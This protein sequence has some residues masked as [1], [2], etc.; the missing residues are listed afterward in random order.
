MLN[1]ILPKVGLKLKRETSPQDTQ[2]K[3]ATLATTSPEVTVDHEVKTEPSIRKKL[4]V[5]RKKQ[6][7]SRTSSVT[8]PNGA[9]PE[10]YGL[11]PIDKTADVDLLQRFEVIRYLDAF[12][13]SHTDQL[14][15]DELRNMLKETLNTKQSSFV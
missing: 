5:T 3:L 12:N 4:L 1:S 11:P 2:P 6:N 7:H 14:E 8:F 9:V 15:E 10:E 13:I